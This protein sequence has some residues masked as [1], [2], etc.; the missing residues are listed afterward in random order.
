MPTM[1]AL[2]DRMLIAAPAPG[3]RV[4]E[5]DVLSR[6]LPLAGADIVELGCGK[7]E[8]SRQIVQR[9]SP[10]SILALEVDEIQHRENLG[11]PPIPGLRFALGG[12]EAIPAPD[13]SFDIVLMFKSLHHVPVDRMDQALAEIR[14]V[15]RPGGLAYL[16]EPVYAGE[17]NDMM[18]VFHDE[19]AVREAAFAAVRRAVAAGLLALV[20][21]KFFRT[22]RR[23]ASFEQFEDQAIKV[24]HTRHDLDPAQLARVRELFMLRMTPEGA[25][26][27]MPMRVDLL[28]KPAA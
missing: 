28:R 4:D 22:R 3:E 11:A 13:A 9:A 7:A 8:K 1:S 27:D 12:A 6:A 23:F 15:L 2:A 26:F 24:T 20:E 21:Q 16:S 19:K 25:S 10:R 14:R 5:F 17:F 18:R